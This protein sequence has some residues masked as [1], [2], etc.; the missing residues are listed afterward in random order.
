MVIFIGLGVWLA[1]LSAQPVE[2]KAQAA[3][4]T[5]DRKMFELGLLFILYSVGLG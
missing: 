1:G 4:K 3:S 2:A 5:A